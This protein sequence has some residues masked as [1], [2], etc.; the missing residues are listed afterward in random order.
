MPARTPAIRTPDTGHRPA[1]RLSPR[2]WLQPA[3]FDFWARH[4]DRTWS[5]E[6]ILARVIERRAASARATTLVL[7]PNRHWP[8]AVAGQHL[9]VIVEIEG[10]RHRRSYSLSA[11]PRADGCIEITVA[12]V[13]GGLVSPVLAR[14]TQVGA[15]LELS[16]PYGGLALSHIRAADRAQTSSGRMAAEL[17]HPSLLVGEGAG[18]R[19]RTHDAG[20]LPLSPTPLPQGERGLKNMRTPAPALLLAAGSGITPLRALLVD[21]LAKGETRAITLLYWA[22]TREELCFHEELLQL[23]QGHPTLRVE[24]LLTRDPEAPAARINATQLQALAPELSASE[25]LACGPDGF[26]ARARELCASARGFQAEGFTAATPE[27]S[28]GAR[29]RVQLKRSGLALDLPTDRPL[30]QALEEAGQTPA[31]GCRRGICNT[32]R[33]DRLAGASRDLQNGALRDEPST[34]IRLCVHSAAHGLVLDL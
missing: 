28:D 12:E 31:F 11:P 29:V 3:V 23:A 2:R 30:L 18:E 27:K 9:D 19:G 15:V 32:C 24:F 7:K 17:T 4:F 26:I 25:V 6:R 21:A 22:Q 13:E 16:A 10:A 8:G 14:M 34:P 20:S 1:S 33:C 5:A